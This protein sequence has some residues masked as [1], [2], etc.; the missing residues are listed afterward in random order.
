MLNLSVIA[1]GISVANHSHVG[2]AHAARRQLFKIVDKLYMTGFIL[3]CSYPCF[4]ECTVSISNLL[5][6]SAFIYIYILDI[7]IDIEKYKEYQ[8]W[9]HILFHAVNIIGVTAIY[10]QAVWLPRSLTGVFID[11]LPG[12]QGR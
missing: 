1:L 4:G 9:C 5:A 7:R 3:Y 2:H 12:K 6:V 8:K 10:E 11:E